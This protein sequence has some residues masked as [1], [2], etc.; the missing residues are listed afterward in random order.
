[1][2]VT[3]SNLLSP[4]IVSRESA[5]PDNGSALSSLSG[6]RD[7]RE[8]SYRNAFII[9][10]PKNGAYRDAT[11]RAHDDILSG[12]AIAL[13]GY[14]GCDRPKLI[15]KKKKKKKESNLEDIEIKKNLYRHKLK[16]IIW[17]NVTYDTCVAF[18]KLACINCFMM[19]G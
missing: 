2:K 4:R 3:A 18:I 13:R 9:D 15:K 17:K 14:Q 16:N 12:F 6:N 10:H 7:S 5:G 8:R 1:M 19:H 11:L